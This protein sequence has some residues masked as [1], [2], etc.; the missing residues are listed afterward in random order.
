MIN[1][2][3]C[4]QERTESVT[5]Y[6]VFQLNLHIIQQDSGGMVHTHYYHIAGN[7]RGRKVVIFK[8]LWLLVKACSTNLGARHP[9]V[10][11][12]SNPRKFCL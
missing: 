3:E 2:D 8:V 9:L 1:L 10:A 11:S 6:M 4:L 12:A 5:E 7:F